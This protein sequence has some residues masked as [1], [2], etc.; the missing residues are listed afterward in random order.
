MFQSKDF[1]DIISPQKGGVAV[2][3]QRHRQLWKR[4]YPT[5]LAELFSHRT[6]GD[7]VPS[8]YNAYSDWKSLSRVVIHFLARLGIYSQSLET[9]THYFLGVEISGSMD[10]A[11]TEVWWMDGSAKRLWALLDLWAYWWSPPTIPVHWSGGCTVAWNS[12]KAIKEPSRIRYRFPNH[13]GFD[14]CCVSDSRIYV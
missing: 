13:S 10:C 12:P 11:I 5:A 8:A 3:W 2:S 1:L 4:F 7:R 14:F 6:P 9:V